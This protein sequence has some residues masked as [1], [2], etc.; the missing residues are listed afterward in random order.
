MFRE[1][2]KKDLDGISPD[3]E[4]LSKISLMMSEEAAK[5]KQPI[6]LNVAKWGTM[7]AAICLVAVGTVAFLGKGNDAIS[8]ETA[9]ADASGLTAEAADGAGYALDMTVEEENTA[10]EDESINVSFSE[11]AYTGR[12]PRFDFNIDASTVQL[13]ENPDLS[14]K[15]IPEG[16]AVIEYNDPGSIS[17]LVDGNTDIVIVKIAGSNEYT[18]G[19]FAGQ[20]ALYSAEAQVI[21]ESELFLAGDIIPVFVPYSSMEANLEPEKYYL[22]II[23]E[24]ENGIF[25]ISSGKESVFEI[26]DDNTVI[27]QSHFRVPSMLDGLTV[28]EAAAVLKYEQDLKQ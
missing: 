5:P 23:T 15:E 9:V 17:D 21:V 20:A 7:A 24:Y 13:N 1:K 14:E 2:L 27:S 18:G 16:N 19:S 28:E 11:E 8:T 22:M 3:E 25:K 6:Y 12:F 10:E 26:T 4:L